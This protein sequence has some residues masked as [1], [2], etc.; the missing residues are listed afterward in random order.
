[1]HGDQSAR[2]LDVL[3]QPPDQV[4]VHLGAALQRDSVATAHLRALADERAEAV[5]FLAAYRAELATANPEGVD[6]RALAAY[7]RTILGSNE[8]LHVD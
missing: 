8:F 2:H 7:L 4:E 3:L 1:M 5:E 6:V